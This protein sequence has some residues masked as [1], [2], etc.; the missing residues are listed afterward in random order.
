MKTAFLYAG[1]GSQSVGMGRDLY[2]EFPEFRETVDSVSLSFDARKLM[3]E[4]PQELLMQTRYTQP[5]M[6]IFAAGVTE[7][8]RKNGLLP[9]MAGGLS[10]GEYGALY[11]AGVWDRDTYIKITEF[12]GR[13]MQEAAEGKHTAMSAIL[14]MSAAQVED[15]CRDCAPVGFVRPVNY[16]CPGQY[17]ICGEEAAVAAAETL[18]K[19]KG[20]KRA[21]R[22]KVS[23]PF[24][25]GLL[26]PAADALAGYFK[27]IAF[28][29][30]QIPV[31]LNLTGGFYR[32]D[33]DLKEILE[34]QAKSSVR[35]EEDLR[36]MIEAGATR[37][38][39]IGPG[40]ALTGFLKKTAKAM[41]AE[42][43]CCSIQTAED[44]CRLIG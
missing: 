1:Q 17:V 23:A 18:L 9:D 29:K 13:A 28:R 38:I 39:E 34:K 10:L 2:E 32:E 5:C 16:N 20:M 27:E 44:L 33:M 7:I 12:R 41:N 30:P 8:L 22:L 11:A 19:E 35:F 26:Q 4:G 37:F 31:A 24:H 21:I 25:T 40:N 15:A 3:W 14:G 43:E 36:A 42:V 6:A